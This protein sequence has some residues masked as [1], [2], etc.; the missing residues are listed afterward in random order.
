MDRLYAPWRANYVKKPKNG[1]ERCVFCSVLLEGPSHD[2]KN[3]ILCRLDEA[4][5]MMNLYPYNSG[6]LLVLPKMHTSN[7]EDLS[8]STYAATTELLRSSINSK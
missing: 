7:L 4:F 6:H 1:D 3:L 8:T 2:E 5:V